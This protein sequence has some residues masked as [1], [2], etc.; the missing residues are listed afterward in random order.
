[1]NS[2]TDTSKGYFFVTVEALRYF[3]LNLWCSI[4]VTNGCI[5]SKLS[6]SITSASLLNSVSSGSSTVGW[7]EPIYQ[8]RSAVGGQ[9]RL[10]L[11]LPVMDKEEF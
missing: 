9:M 2:I 8:G 7:Q 4:S 5:W 1:M 3:K 10:S 6:D 11:S